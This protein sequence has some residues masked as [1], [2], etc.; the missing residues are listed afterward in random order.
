MTI[1]DSNLA[2]QIVK[3]EQSDAGTLHFF[4]DIAVV[5][6]NEG[7]HVDLN[8]ARKTIHDLIHYF[9]NSKPFGLIANRVN[10]YSISLLET[11][12]V[13]SIFPN[14]VAY[15]VVSHN[16]AGRMNAEIESN[17]CASQNISFDNLY[18]GLHAVHK[19]VIEQI[20]I[21]IN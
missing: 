1:L 18:E 10:S 13:K 16:Y 3:Q 6:F 17:F 21:S 12:E 14:L 15:G 4:N 11:L 2:S 19:K 9:G 20:A 7:V 8:T 5:E